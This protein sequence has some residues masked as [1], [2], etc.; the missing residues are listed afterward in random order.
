MYGVRRFCYL[1]AVVDSGEGPLWPCGG[2]GGGGQG[3]YERG[4]H[5]L[6]DIKF[7][8]DQSTH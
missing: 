8:T 6:R 5:F 3:L 1:S 2:G 7:A 4:P